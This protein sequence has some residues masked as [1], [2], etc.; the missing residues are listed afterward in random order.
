MT[1]VIL[2]IEPRLLSVLED[3]CNHF[4]MPREK[5]LSRLLLIGA[6]LFLLDLQGQRDR[7]D[8]AGERMIYA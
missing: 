2:E 5:V 3:V 1:R 6:H 7:E 4:N 8:D